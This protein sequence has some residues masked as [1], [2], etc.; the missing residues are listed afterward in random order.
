MLPV[1]DLHRLRVDER[2]ERVVR[3]GKR[4]EFERHVFLLW[5][6]RIVAILACGYPSDEASDVSFT[7]LARTAAGY[8]CFGLSRRE[9]RAR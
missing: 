5:N 9:G 8:T 7:L 3:T 2:L 6:V 4:G 1:V